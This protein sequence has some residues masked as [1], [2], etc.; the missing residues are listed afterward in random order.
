MIEAPKMVHRDQYSE[1]WRQAKVSPAVIS[2]ASKR[3]D[4]LPA[5]VVY[6]VATDVSEAG[7]API[8]IPYSDEHV[9][10]HDKMFLLKKLGYPISTDA[11]ANA[12]LLLGE[13][14]DVIKNT[15]L[16][17]LKIVIGVVGSIGGLIW[18]LIK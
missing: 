13:T 3:Y 2:L 11:S 7:V 10:L 16:T 6:A 12:D 9:D 8:E 4:Y 18:Y 1:I 15:A 14:E 5:S 17:P